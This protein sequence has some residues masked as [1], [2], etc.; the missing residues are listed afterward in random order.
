MNVHGGIFTIRGEED[1]KSK[2]FKCVRDANDKY[3]FLIKQ[4]S[5]NAVS[6]QDQVMRFLKNMAI[7]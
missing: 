2:M 3:L 7:N 6:H 4:A 1:R 5:K